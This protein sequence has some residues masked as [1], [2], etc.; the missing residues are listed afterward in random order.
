MENKSLPR[1]CIF[2]LCAVSCGNAQA[3][4]ATLKFGVFSLFKSKHLLVRPARN[5]TVL[6]TISETTLT[7]DSEFEVRSGREG[8]RV[9]GDGHSYNAESLLVTSRDG[10]ASEFAL[11]VPGKIEREF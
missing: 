8:L 9:V 4:P 10:G 11:I 1:L 6:L 2:L 5:Q 7:L 3:V